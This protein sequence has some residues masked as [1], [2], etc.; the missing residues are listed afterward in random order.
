MLVQ[1]VVATEVDRVSWINTGNSRYCGERSGRFESDGNV[2]IPN[3]LNTSGVGSSSGGIL[4]VS[5]QDHSRMLKI[6]KSDGLATF[7]N[8][9][10]YPVSSLGLVHILPR[11]TLV[12]GVRCIFGD[13]VP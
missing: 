3:T 11:D 10:V 7:T 1:H 5:I 6:R 12:S 13:A 8:V 2:S 9:P 4:V